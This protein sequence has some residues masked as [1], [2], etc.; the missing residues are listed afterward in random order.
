MLGTWKTQLPGTE[1]WLLSW[2]SG[3]FVTLGLIVDEGL[4]GELPLCALVGKHTL[5]KWCHCQ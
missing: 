4:A 1:S 5:L 2:Q 3:S